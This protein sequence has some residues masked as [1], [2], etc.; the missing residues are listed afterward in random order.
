MYGYSLYSELFIDLLTS[1]YPWVKRMGRGC[2]SEIVT[3]YY[4]MAG[5]DSHKHMMVRLIQ[6]RQHHTNES[7]F[8]I[9]AINKYMLKTDIPKVQQD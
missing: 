7:G 9:S 6:V 1:D 3:P 8:V 4:W 2:Q 5:A